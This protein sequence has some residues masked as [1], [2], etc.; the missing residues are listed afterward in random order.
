MVPTS[1][2]D[3]KSKWSLIELLNRFPMTKIIAT[4]DLEL[5]RASCQRTII[6]DEGKIAADGRTENI[7]DDIMPLKAHGLAH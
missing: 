7:L 1:N 6:M 3:P 4:H 5:V 2:L